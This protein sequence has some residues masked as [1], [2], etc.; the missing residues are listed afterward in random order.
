MMLE[1]CYLPRTTMA[2]ANA[3]GRSHSRLKR[4]WRSTVQHM[5]TVKD[6]GGIWHIYICMYVY[7]YIYYLY[8]IRGILWGYTMGHKTNEMIVAVSESHPDLP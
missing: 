4:D 3:L 7:I 8:I 5:G 2:L 6:C 1:S